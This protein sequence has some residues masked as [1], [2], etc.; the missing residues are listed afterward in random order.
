MYIPGV[1]FK[2]IV[3]GDIWSYYK[4]CT[5]SISGISTVIE[6]AR[7]SIVTYVF[8]RSRLEIVVLSGI[9]KG[10]QTQ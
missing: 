8:Y 10:P 9:E 6:S 4:R 5:S 7:Y 1:D 3:G 2:V